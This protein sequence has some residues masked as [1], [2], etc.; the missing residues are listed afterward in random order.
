M[1]LKPALAAFHTILLGN[2]SGLFY[3]FRDPHGATVTTA[4]H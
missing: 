2:G 1:K 3:S 4:I